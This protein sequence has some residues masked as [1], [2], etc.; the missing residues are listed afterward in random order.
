V[1]EAVHSGEIRR[2]HYDNYLKLRAES[3]FYQMSYAGKRKKDRD[4]GR[5]IKSVKKGLDYD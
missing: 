5:F 4:F 3:E 2:D 1:L